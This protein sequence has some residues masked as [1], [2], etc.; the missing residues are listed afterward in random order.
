MQDEALLAD[1]LKI[2]AGEANGL[3][4]RDRE[5]L[6]K[7]AVLLDEVLTVY[8]RVYFRLQDVEGQLAAAQERLREANRALIKNNV[9]PEL[10]ATGKIIGWHP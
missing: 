10:K 8:G 5:S 6:R 2:I 1:E 4:A 3:T 9:F 7:S